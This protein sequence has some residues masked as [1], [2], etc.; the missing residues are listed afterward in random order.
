MFR[1]VSNARSLHLG[2]SHVTP[3]GAAR[4]ARERCSD[5]GSGFFAS[6]LR[7]RL[8]SSLSGGEAPRCRLVRQGVPAATRFGV[9]EAGPGGRHG[10]VVRCQE[11]KGGRDKVFGT[12][13][14]EMVCN[15]RKATAPVMGCGC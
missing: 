6:V 9:S 13:V 15:N 4:E 3:S 7:G 5:P 11:S 10:N 14:P 8:E 1:F 12:S 2:G